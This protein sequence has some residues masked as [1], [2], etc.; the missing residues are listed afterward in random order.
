M[1][2]KAGSQQQN[3]TETAIVLL[4]LTGTFIACAKDSI[5]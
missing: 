4:D 1:L 5:Y 2:L 3:K